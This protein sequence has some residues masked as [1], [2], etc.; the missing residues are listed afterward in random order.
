MG[1]PA[2]RASLPQQPLRGTSLTPRLRDTV[3]K[4]GVQRARGCP[5]PLLLPGLRP[6]V[7]T[8]AAPTLPALQGDTPH[9][10]L[11]DPTVT[12]SQGRH[13]VLPFCLLLGARR[14][15]ATRD[16]ALVRTRQGLEAAVT[17]DRRTCGEGRHL[18][19]APGPAQPSRLQ[20]L[21]PADPAK[22]QRSDSAATPGRRARPGRRAPRPPGTSGQ[23]L[24]ASP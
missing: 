13:R 9:Q 21:V 20:C 14:G 2:G 19:A 4:G 11:S 12:P 8:P 15:A 6:P 16:A 17:G 10:E 5:R 7:P 1:A 23:R 18:S 3:T 24:P 22:Q